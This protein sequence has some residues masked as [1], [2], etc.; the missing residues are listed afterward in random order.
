MVMFSVSTEEL[1]VGVQPAPPEEGIRASSLMHQPCG[2]GGVLFLVFTVGDTRCGLRAGG[3]S[4]TFK[5]VSVSLGPV[6]AAGSPEGLASAGP[7]FWAGRR[8]SMCV[9]NSRVPWPGWGGGL[10]GDTG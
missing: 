7:S 9:C 1:G 4:E 2:G 8:L 10:G 5:G 6:L 3:V